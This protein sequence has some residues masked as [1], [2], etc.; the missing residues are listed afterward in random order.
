MSKT[1]ISA[2]L[3]GLVVA[4]I[5]LVFLGLKFAPIDRPA[6]PPGAVEK[7]FLNCR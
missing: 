3:A 6:C 2:A 4:S 7:L 5:G 1:A